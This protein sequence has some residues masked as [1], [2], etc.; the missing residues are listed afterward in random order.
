ML[1]VKFGMVEP[2][3]SQKPC[4]FHVDFNYYF[5]HDF[6]HDFLHN[7]TAL[8]GLVMAVWPT[9]TVG[10]QILYRTASQR[11]HREAQKQLMVTDS[12][13]N[14]KYFIRQCRDMFHTH[15][16]YPYYTRVS[17][18]DPCPRAVDTGSV[19]RAIHE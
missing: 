4:L 13:R 7:G 19:Y 14:A 16:E 17:K 1:P 8:S 5:Y 9:T 18:N 3:T 6:N 10:E 11:L 2:V 15:T 12:H